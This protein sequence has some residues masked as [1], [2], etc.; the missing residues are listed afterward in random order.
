MNSGEIANWTTRLAE[1]APVHFLAFRVLISNPWGL[2]CLFVIDYDNN[3]AK[4]IIERT[5]AA[6]GERSRCGGGDY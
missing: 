6:A 4:N 5:G 2:I 3:G 1:G